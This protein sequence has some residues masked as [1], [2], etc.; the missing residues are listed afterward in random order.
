M[1]RDIEKVLVSEEQIKEICQRLGSKLTNDYKNKKPI[2]LG[3][4]KGCLPFMSD[5]LKFVNVKG[6]IEYMDVGSYHGGIESSGDIK[7]NYDLNIPIKDRDVI[8]IEDI[9]DTGKTIDTVVKLL[10]H[11]G[12][13]SIKVVTLLDKPAGRVLEFVPDYVGMTIPKAFVV[14][15]GLDYEEIYRNLPYV[16]ILK[17]DVYTSKREV[18]ND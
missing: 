4:L 9:V 12:A 8:L 17:E 13:R 1:H 15:Y 10:K 3:L 7:I 14:G 2:F 16:G 11:R 18:E 6:E 5:L